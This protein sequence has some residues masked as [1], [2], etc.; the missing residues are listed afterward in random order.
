LNVL[1]F[2]PEIL[3]TYLPY[4]CMFMEEIKTHVKEQ[5]RL[6]SH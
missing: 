5:V 1:Q 3:P 2:D 4:L 6:F